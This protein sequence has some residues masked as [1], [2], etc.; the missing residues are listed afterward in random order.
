MVL[1]FGILADS[2]TNF[3]CNLDV[4]T[5]KRGSMHEVG[6][7]RRVVLKLTEFISNTGRHNTGDNFFTS[8]LLVRTLLGRKSGEF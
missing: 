6:Q 2:R 7:G 3:C 1:R 5:E 4:H 8:L